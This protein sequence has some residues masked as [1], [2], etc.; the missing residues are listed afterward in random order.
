MG[1]SDPTITIPSVMIAEADA[2]TSRSFLSFRSR[3]HSGM[4][5]TVGIDPN[6]RFGADPA[7]RLLL[8]TPN[9]YSATSSVSHWDPIAFPN[10]LMEPTVNGDVTH[11]TSAPFDLTL[12][13]LHDIGW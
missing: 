8:Y 1:G 5:A 9:P 6:Q 11:N 13:F 10:L 12:E 3:T 4:F 2:A 7:G